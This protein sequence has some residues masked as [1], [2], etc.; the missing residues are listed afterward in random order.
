M[1][2]ER[3]MILNLLSEGK[4]SA[5]E[6]E[7]LLD[8]L[9]DDA[10]ALTDLSGHGE[11]QRQ[12][13]R[14]G[15]GHGQW[16]LPMS[17]RISD[18]LSERLSKVAGEMAEAGQEIPARLYRAF[19]SMAGAIGRASRT[20]GVHAERTFEGEISGERGLS[21]IDFSA[22]NGSVKVAGWDKAGYRVTVR[23]SVRG[24]ESRAAA[25]QSLASE[26]KL[27]FEGGRMSIECKDRSLL[28]SMSIEA[29]V[30]SQMGGDITLSTRNGSVTLE[31][32]QAGRVEARSSNGRVTL[33]ALKAVSVNASAHNGAMNASG[34]L[35]DATLESANG[36]V[37]MILAYESAGRVRI[38]TANGSIRVIAPRAGAVVYEI[39][40]ET[41]NGTV[42]SSI[43]GARVE[44]ERESSWGRMRRL[45]V[46]TQGDE[47][48]PRVA[49]DA[50]ATN[51][52]VTLENA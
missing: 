16:Q 29:Y 49:V 46:M 26:A 15:H 2:E 21:A 11:E 22:L 19:E 34:G 51:G 30:P 40:A 12:D 17:G 28:D 31:K 48:G 10:V 52:S 6:A 4:I 44:T 20:I 25:E 23:A 50:C 39:A 1:T 36:S 42:K 38:R 3:K 13:D 27:L 35:G 43:E 9:G 41:A 32:V 33:D 7:E 8:A 47:G 18:E 37:S 14:Q 45:R 24:A 5:E